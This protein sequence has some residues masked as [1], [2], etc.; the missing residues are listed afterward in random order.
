MS[1]YVLALDTNKR[2]LDPI[3]PAAARKL[4]AEGRVAVFRTYP[5]TIILKDKSDA[6]TKPIEIKLDP[7]SKNTGMGAD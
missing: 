4:L 2:P 5:F 7:G 3:H 6:P 1:N